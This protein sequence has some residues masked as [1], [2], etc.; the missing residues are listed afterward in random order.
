MD[1]DKGANVRPELFCFLLVFYVGNPYQISFVK[2]ILLL[3][4]NKE[5]CHFKN[6]WR[7]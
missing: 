4:N 1:T 6:Q 3:N 7:K 5:K 2:R